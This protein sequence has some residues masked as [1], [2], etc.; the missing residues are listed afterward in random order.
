MASSA[1]TAASGA[2]NLGGQPVT[3]TASRGYNVAIGY[4][5]GFLVILVLAHHSAV[6]YFWGVPTSRAPLLKIPKLWRAFP[7]VD[8]HA[9]SALMTLFVSFNDTFFMAL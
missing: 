7:V 4:L 1:M 6:A 3:H 9:H 2:P 5:R 8:P